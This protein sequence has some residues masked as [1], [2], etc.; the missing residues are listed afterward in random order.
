LV[1]HQTFDFILFAILGI[2]FVI[3]LVGLIRP[4][5]LEPLIREPSGGF[6]SER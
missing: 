6:G 1:N 2:P 3:G 4:G 5:L